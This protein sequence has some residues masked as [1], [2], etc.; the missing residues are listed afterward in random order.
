MIKTQNVSDVSI[1]GI[2]S[3][4]PEKIL[5]NSD[6]E[7][8][9]DTSDE[10]IV[11][12]T[13]IKERRIVEDG[14]ATSDLAVKA[15]LKALEDANVKPSEIDLIITSTITPDHFFPSTSC[16]VQE[17]IG[18]KNAGAFDV[19]AACAGFVYALSIAKSFVSSGMMITVLVIGAECLSKITDYEDRSSCILFGDG[20]GAVVLQKGTGRYEVL[21]CILGADGS[22][23]DLLILPAGGSRHPTTKQ[24]LDDR[25]HFMKLKG[26]ELFKIATNNFVALINETVLKCG[27][28][29]EDISLI[30][31]HQSN[32]RI[33]N[34][35]MKKLGLPMDRV[36]VNID[37][38]GNTSSASV[39][40]AIDQAKQDGRLK[41]GD[42]IIL[43]AFGGGLTWSSTILKW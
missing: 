26:K 43:A 36:V 15:S 22:K 2:G 1:T 41:E 27:V 20:A 21:D 37:K 38:C 24:T 8:M 3:F 34:M 35:A 19:L 6:L 28:K 33:I 17:M 11:K 9:V 40:I 29:L 14:V 31:P 23:G 13:G 39:P 32:L 16:R 5:S 4:L 10:W 30:I 42:L 25:M 7:E 18:A 12:R